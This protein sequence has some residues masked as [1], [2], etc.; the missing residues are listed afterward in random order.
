[1]A[2]SIP[3]GFKISVQEPVDNRI[4]LTKSEMA[5][6]LDA[7]MPSNYICV[8]KDD[9]KLYIYNE[10][11]SVSLETGKFRLYEDVIDIPAAVLKTMQTTEGKATM[12]EAVSQTLPGAMKDALEDPILGQEMVENMFDNEQFAL[13]V[14]N[15]VEFKVNEAISLIEA[16]DGMV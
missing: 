14:D 12:E 8:C 7:K 9:G 3:S 15:K 4:V 2:I 11:N 5:Q 1:M 16:I 10:A 13:N 6:M